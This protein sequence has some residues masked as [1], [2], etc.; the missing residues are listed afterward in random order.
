MSISL[1]E[2]SI[3]YKEQILDYKYE[4]IENSEQLHG[5]AGLA[6]AKTVEGWLEAIKKN[7]KEETVTKGL[8][9]ASTYLIINEEDYLVGFIDIRHR[10]NKYLELHGGHIGYSVRKSERKKGYGKEAL[11]LGLEKCRALNIDRVLVTCDP[12]NIPSIKTILA[13]GGVFENEVVDKNESTRRYWINL[14]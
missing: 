10:L 9:P 5:T 7:S 14:K 1:I 4:F 6:N 11:K 8:V 3:K 2:P 13:N 12:D